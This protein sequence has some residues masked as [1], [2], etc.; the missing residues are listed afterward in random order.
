MGRRDGFG[1]F[2]AENLSGDPRIEEFGGFGIDGELSDLSFG[3]VLG[4][5]ALRGRLVVGA[6]DIIAHRIDWWTHSRFVIETDE[7]GRARSIEGADRWFRALGVCA[8][9]DEQNSQGRE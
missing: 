8:I 3:N 6:D 7:A 5:F 1:K 2:G 4:C 9:E